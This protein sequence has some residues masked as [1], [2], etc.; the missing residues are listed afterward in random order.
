M[1]SA[2][3]RLSDM[4]DSPSKVIIIDHSDDSEKEKVP[5]LHLG[6]GVGETGMEIER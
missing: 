3:R 6:Y 4:M 1:G 5:A 2:K